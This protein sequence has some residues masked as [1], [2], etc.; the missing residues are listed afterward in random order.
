M[1]KGL[2]DARFRRTEDALFGVIFEEGGMK[3]S[4]VEIARRIGVNRGTLYRHHRAMREIIKD[5]E[6]YILEKYAELM[7][8]IRKRDSVE[9]RRMYY[10]MVLFILQNRR[11]F[12]MLIKQKNFKVLDEMIV[13]LKPEIMDFI[14]LSGSHERIFRVYTGEIVG[15]ITDWELDGFREVEIVKL[16]NNIMYLTESARRRLL[17]LAN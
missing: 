14:R 2:G 9:L 10:E 5:Y 4:V 7:I 17:S 15:L 1:T 8:E 16:L 13:V 6:Q 12:E 11:I 3:L